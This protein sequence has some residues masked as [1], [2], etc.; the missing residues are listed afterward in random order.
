M[1][2]M[3]IAQKET[4]CNWNNKEAASTGQMYNAGFFIIRIQPFCK[5]LNIV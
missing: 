1:D 5:P 4:G 3:L 2:N